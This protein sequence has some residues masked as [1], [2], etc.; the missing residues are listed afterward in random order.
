ME[1]GIGEKRSRGKSGNKRSKS[2]DR[3]TLGSAL[4]MDLKLVGPRANKVISQA[5]LTCSAIDCTPA[6]RLHK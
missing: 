5:A 1:E 4:K 2:R 6:G 3:G